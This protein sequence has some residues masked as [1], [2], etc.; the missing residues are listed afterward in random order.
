MEKKGKKNTKQTNNNNKNPKRSKQTKKQ[1][2]QRKSTLA[3]AYKPISVKNVYVDTYCWS[4]QFESIVNDRCLHSRP[5]LQGWE[6]PLF[7]GPRGHSR[8]S[9]KFGE[10][11]FYVFTYII[12]AS[13]W[14]RALQLRSCPPFYPD[15][16]CLELARRRTVC[17]WPS[18]VRVCAFRGG[19]QARLWQAKIGLWNFVTRFSH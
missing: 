13:C 2:D 18:A 14:R 19:L 15:S 17:A 8:D 7:D 9:S 3:L 6:F 4:L 11:M 16:V 5:Q 12:T 10:K 1:R